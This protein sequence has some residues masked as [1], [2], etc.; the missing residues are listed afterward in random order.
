[1]KELLANLTVPVGQA[2]VDVLFVLGFFILITAYNIRFGKSRSLSLLFSLSLG[3]FAYLAFPY[4]DVLPFIEGSDVQRIIVHMAVFVVF[5]LVFQKI[6]NRYIDADYPLSFARRLFES[7]LIALLGTALITAFTYN[8]ITVTAT[9]D[10][11]G[12]ML[13]QYLSASSAFFW[14]L[15][16][17][18]ILLFFIRR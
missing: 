12:A 8:A 11:T 3:L 4:F 18:V 13:Y 2:S 10:L 14:W 6:F 7:A 15:I 1:M 17:P 9:Y 16:I 5:V